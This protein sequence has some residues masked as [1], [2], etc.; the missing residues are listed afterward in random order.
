MSYG[1]VV[2]CCHLMGFHGNDHF[3]DGYGVAVRH[4]GSAV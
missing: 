1:L 4:F 3:N 2:R